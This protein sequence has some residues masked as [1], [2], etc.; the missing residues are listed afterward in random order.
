MEFTLRCA[1]TGLESCR[2]RGS[3]ESVGDKD[4]M[5]GKFRNYHDYRSFL[6]MEDRKL[7]GL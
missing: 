3:V 7:I 5:V 6:V 2:R 4:N 1:C